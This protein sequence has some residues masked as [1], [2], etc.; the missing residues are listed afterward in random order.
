MATKLLT[1]VIF[2]AG[3]LPAAD[4]AI[5]IGKVLG[6]H[7]EFSLFSSLLSSTGVARA[8]NS[9]EAVTVLA[10]NNTAVVA[11]LRGVPRGADTR[12]LLSDVLSLHVIL[13]YID[14][15]KLELLAEGRSGDG[16]RVTTLL[17]ANGKAQGRYAGFVHISVGEEEYDRITFTS[18][19]IGSPWNATFEKAIAQLPPS[20]SVL[21]I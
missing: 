7:R 9:R 11:A 21:Q 12:A 18:G 16:T 13:E 20:V 10:P 19:A 5:D 2:L 15:D 8:T 14:A 3:V 1:F 6:E 4:A 17:Q